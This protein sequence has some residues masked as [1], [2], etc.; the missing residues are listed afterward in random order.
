V[1]GRRGVLP[2]VVALVAGLVTWAA[3]ASAVDSGSASLDGGPHRFIS[4]GT[5][6]VT[7]TV[8]SGAGGSVTATITNANGTSVDLG[9]VVVGQDDRFALSA[10]TG[11]LADGG[12]GLLVRTPP[13]ATWPSGQQLTQGLWVRQD[14]AAVTIQ[15]PATGSTVTALSAEG[16]LPI[17][18]RT[19]SLP[20]AVNTSASY[21]YVMVGD[22]AVSARVESA[23]AACL[24]VEDIPNGPATVWVELVGDSP[25]VSRLGRADVTLALTSHVELAAVSIGNGAFEG[26]PWSGGG[27]R[28]VGTITAAGPD[29]TV[30]ATLDGVAVPVQ[31]AAPLPPGSYGRR[32]T[33]EVDAWT[34]GVEK[35]ADGVHTWRATSTSRGVT[36]DLGSF[37]VTVSSAGRLDVTSTSETSGVIPISG[38]V[39]NVMR[40]SSRPTLTYTAS[41]AGSDPVV[42]DDPNGTTITYDAVLGASR[43]STTIPAPEGTGPVKLQVSGVDTRSLPVCDAVTISG[44]TVTAATCDPVIPAPPGVVS[45]VSSGYGSATVTLSPPAVTGGAPITGYTVTARETGGATRTFRSVGSDPH[46]Q[47]ADLPVGDIR[48][49]LAATAE[50]SAGSSLRTVAGALGSLTAQYEPRSASIPLGSSLTFGFRLDTAGAPASDYP[51]QVQFRRTGT[52]TWTIVASLTAKDGQVLNSVRL[53]PT[54]SGSYRLAVGGQGRVVGGVFEPVQVAVLG[55]PAVTLRLSP[56]RVKLRSKVTFSGSVV[57]GTRGQKVSIQRNVKGSWQTVLSATTTATGAYKAV[58]KVRTKT[59]Y[60]WR[61]VTAAG[62]GRPAGA[63]AAVLLKVR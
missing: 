1:L 2:V 14:T 21:A 54:A 31:L 56:S 42:V 37:D 51:A 36:T 60:R 44:G 23:T 49:T 55:P 8:P 32:V 30:S 20:F 52:S 7:G 46:V 9:S 33:A 38:E 29:T 47:L 59:A 18:F 40:T 35:L 16:C 41:R 6:S 58:Y 26:V 62:F 50:N 17:T 13:T 15:S 12:H 39:D 61:A 57:P 34:D 63:S 27:A 3:P 48:W 10:P 19:G 22:A 4:P 25:A 28:L 5:L 24:P 45:V 53:T 11:A 43:F